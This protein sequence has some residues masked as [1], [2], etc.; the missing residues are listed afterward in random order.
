MNCPICNQE[1]EQGFFH[2][3]SPRSSWT[4]KIHK[5]SLLPKAGDILFENNMFKQVIF[6][7]HICKQCKKVVLD[8]SDK[9]IQES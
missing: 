7:A 8:Y 5:V 9:D 2:S 6:T 4:K 1:M 3:G